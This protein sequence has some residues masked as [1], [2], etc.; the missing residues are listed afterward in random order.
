MKKYILNGCLFAGYLIYILFLIKITTNDQNKLLSIVG[1]IPFG[2]LCGLK[3]FTSKKERRNFFSISSLL[4]VFFF[5]YHLFFGYNLGNVVGQLGNFAM[6][7]LHIIILYKFLI[8]EDFQDTRYA[9]LGT[10]IVVV[11]VVFIPSY[12]IVGGL[13]IGSYYNLLSSQL[14]TVS[15]VEAPLLI[16]MLL[17][18]S[19]YDMVFVKRYSIL[20]IASV[21]FSIFLLLLFNRRGFL[22]SSLLSIAFYY[23]FY[24]FNLGRLIYLLLVPLFCQCIGNPYPVCWL[25]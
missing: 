22:F 10:L 6:I 18:F 8:R 16:S 14:L 21:L 12:Q 3:L 19:F 20:N 5:I 9:V 2:V 23:V 24:R 4:I 17:L 11:T 25:L 1:L 13:R 7:L 15:T